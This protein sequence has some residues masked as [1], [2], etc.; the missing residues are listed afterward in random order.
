MPMAKVAV[1]KVACAV[2]SS[3]PVPKVVA[4]SRKVTVPDGVP[5]AGDV[6]TTKA[7]K[8]TIWPQTAGCDE[9]L[10]AVVVAPL[11]TTW[12]EAESVPVLLVKLLEPL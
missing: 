1:V 6:A 8:V 12:A 4:P 10:I 3:E 2:P 7:V 11:L 9:P 5:T